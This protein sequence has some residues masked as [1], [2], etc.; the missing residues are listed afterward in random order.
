MDSGFMIGWILGLAAGIG[1][2]IS[3]GIS[4]GRKQKQWSELT[5]TEKRTRIISI[6]AGV[7]LFIAGVIVLLVRLLT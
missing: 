2:G 1:V 5:D 6:T 4:I 3:I 7:V